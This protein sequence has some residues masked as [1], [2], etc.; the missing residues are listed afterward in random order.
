MEKYM[1]EM[2]RKGWSRAYFEVPV[3]YE[4]EYKEEKPEDFLSSFHLFLEGQK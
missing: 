1:E 4:E 2:E 3:F